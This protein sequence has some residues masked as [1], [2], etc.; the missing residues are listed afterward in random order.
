[1]GGVELCGIGDDGGLDRGASSEN[2]PA[3]SL[4]LEGS[5]E[6]S[7]AD[8]LLIDRGA[9]CVSSRSSGMFKSFGSVDATRLRFV[10][11]SCG[12]PSYEGFCWRE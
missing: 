10:G 7:R 5:A 3:A 12:F 9:N 2:M 4:G 11:G 8:E 1:M 6:L